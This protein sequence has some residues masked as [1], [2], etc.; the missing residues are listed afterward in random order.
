MVTN[1]FIECVHS[2]YRQGGT[3]LC[4]DTLTYLPVRPEQDSASRGRR[5]KLK[6]TQSEALQSLTAG[7]ETRM[8][9]LVLS[10]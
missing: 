10:L 9:S 4:K 8:A 2:C 3:Q 5:R 6:G 1:I 7:K